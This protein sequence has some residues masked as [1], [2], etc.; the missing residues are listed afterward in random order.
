[1]HSSPPTLQQR[2]VD[3]CKSGE[4]RPGRALGPK[5]GPTVV[6]AQAQ[7]VGILTCVSAPFITQHADAFTAPLILPSQAFDSLY[8]QVG[9]INAAPALSNSAAASAAPAPNHPRRRLASGESS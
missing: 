2:L 8:S 9:N 1:M 3:V 4:H 5:K 6:Q 7:G